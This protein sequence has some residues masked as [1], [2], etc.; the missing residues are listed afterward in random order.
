MR[1]T[2]AIDGSAAS[3][4]STIADKL[5]KKF[6]YLYL[7][8]GVMYRSV[9]WAALNADLDVLDEAAVSNLAER[10]D[11]QLLPPT[12]HD[13]RQ[14]TV[15]VEGQDITWLIRRPDIDANVAR[16]S[17][18]PRVRRAMTTRQRAI[19]RQGPVVMVGRDIGTVVLPEADLKIFTQAS[20]EVRAKRRYKE[21]L[22]QGED[23]TYE[24][25]LQSMAQR[26]KLDREKPISPMVPAK[27]AIII[28]TDVLTVEQVL[29]RVESLMMAECVVAQH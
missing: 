15:L 26:D 5:A 21:C 14:L 3:G 4:K 18:Y 13:G 19:A 16:V 27:D 2:I 20:L 11:L 6:N 7:D 24:Q 23:V 10:F 25:V 12:H 1:K 28:N 9:T 8:T 17:S 22:A 29:A